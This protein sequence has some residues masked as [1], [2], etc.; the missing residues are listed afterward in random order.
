MCGTELA[1]LYMISFNLSKT[2]SYTL[3]YPPLQMRKSRPRQ[4]KCLSEVTRLG[5]ARA[6]SCTQVTLPPEPGKFEHYAKVPW[7]GAELGLW[8][9]EGG[10]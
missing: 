5:R 3:L 2:V 10:K 1:A 4:E 9:K 8:R 6:R 7:L